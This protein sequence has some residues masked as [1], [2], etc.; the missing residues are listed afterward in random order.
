MASSESDHAP[1]MA[2]A[3][4]ATLDAEAQVDDGA[5]A[6]PVPASA[7]RR[8]AT[9]L[10]ASFA[11]ATALA[12]LALRRAPGGASDAVLAKASIE[13]SSA[14]W[15]E[16]VYQPFA[17][18]A[19][20][21]AKE[22]GMRCQ[23]YKWWEDGLFAKRS[24][25]VVIKYPGTCHGGIGDT[26][27]G[28]ATAALYA[29]MS[30]RTLHFDFPED[31]RAAFIPARGVDWDAAQMT[32]LKDY[33]MISCCREDCEVDMHWNSE[34][35]VIQMETTRC[36][37]CEWWSRGRY[38]SHDGPYEHFLAAQNLNREDVDL[39]E[40]GGCL[41]R[42]ALEPSPAVWSRVAPL[43]NSRPLVCAHMRT[44]CSDSKADCNAWAAPGKYPKDTPKQ[45]ASCMLKTLETL[46]PNNASSGATSIVASDSPKAKAAIISEL[47]GWKQAP[48]AKTLCHTDGV[49]SNECTIET[50][51]DFM[52]LALCDAIVA[53]K[54]VDVGGYAFPPSGFS[55]YANI[56]SLK[57]SD[58]ILLATEQ[59]HWVPE[60][61]PTA[62]WS[63]F[64][65][66]PPC[67]PMPDP[68]RVDQGNWRCTRQKI[69][70]MNK[71]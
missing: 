23:K 4:A 36:F 24:K 43:M 31:F 5:V 46:S 9:L 60:K 50:I 51:V 39:W 66:E 48:T 22:A 15:S 26:L 63:R 35:P 2:A 58:A 57:G 42:A 27:G 16:E 38:R 59:P 44:G 40:F 18:E 19:Q 12:L 62:Y 28:V 17:A 64:T 47:P 61:I 41:L 52:S 10:L 34:A 30:N 7:W 8:R 71:R 53:Q 20:Q 45:M 68:G 56:Y 6:I 55:R 65:E 29:L 33:P 1:L 54:R 70:G 32:A 14:K 25:K 3:A 69:W 49:R 37:L 13:R 21:F 11:L 67:S